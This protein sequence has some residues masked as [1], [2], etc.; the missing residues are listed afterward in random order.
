MIDEALKS[1]FDINTTKVTLN[2]RSQELIK[3]LT[4]K[5]ITL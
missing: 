4:D 2:E 5:K 3:Y 1:K